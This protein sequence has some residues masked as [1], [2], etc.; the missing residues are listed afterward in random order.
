[1]WI[2]GGFSEKERC[3]IERTD[4]RK[5]RRKRKGDTMGCGADR[6]MDSSAAD[7]YW[8]ETELKKHTLAWTLNHTQVLM[9]ASTHRKELQWDTHTYGHW[10]LHLS[11]SDASANIN[12]MSHHATPLITANKYHHGAL[13]QQ[14]NGYC[15]HR[16]RCDY[17]F[18]G[19]V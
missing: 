5:A 17:R 15:Q 14:V 3:E 10:V 6:L 8:V 19:P 18:V 2:K 11:I 1:M 4:W 7:G 9:K 12:N 16:S 13:T